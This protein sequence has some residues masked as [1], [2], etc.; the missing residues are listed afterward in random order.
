MQNKP[1]F[2]NVLMAITLA[3]TMATNYEPPTTNYSKQ[4]QSNPIY[5]GQSLRIGEWLGVGEGFVGKKPVVGVPANDIQGR[6]S[7]FIKLVKK[8]PAVDDAKDAFIACQKFSGLFYAF[9]RNFS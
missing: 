4:T 6:G 9:E 1:N 3:I 8:T 7:C 5:G 2:E